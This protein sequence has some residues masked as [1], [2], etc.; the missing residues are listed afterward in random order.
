MGAAMSKRI[1]GVECPRCKKRMFSF[2]VHDYK[3]C[4]CYNECMVDGGREYLR[5][6]WK[7]QK[8]RR[9]YWCKKDGEYPKI[10][11]KDRWPY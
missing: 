2:H 11:I 9:I 4:G 10:N 7:V 6:G 3:L 8:P 1:W 5:F